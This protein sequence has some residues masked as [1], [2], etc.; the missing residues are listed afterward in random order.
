MPFNLNY[1][2]TAYG[3]GFLERL[4][5]LPKRII[6]MISQASGA[7]STE[8]KDYASSVPQKSNHSWKETTSRDRGHL[9]IRVL[10]LVGLVGDF[11]N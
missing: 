11:G 1:P 9:P 10:R 5:A 2:S 3:Y 8:I 7:D 6:L 4:D